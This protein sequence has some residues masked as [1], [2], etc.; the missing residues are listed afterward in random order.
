MVPIRLLHPLDLSHC[1][2]NGHPGIDSV[3]VVQVDAVNAEAFQTAFACLSDVLRVAADI[4]FAAIAD[5]GE[6]RCDLNLFPDPFYCLDG[7]GLRL[8]LQRGAGMR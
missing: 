3:L 2:F 5:D 1:D 4:R 7:E 8:L 6:F